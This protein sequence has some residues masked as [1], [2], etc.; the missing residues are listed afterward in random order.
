MQDNPVNIRSVDAPLELAWFADICNGDYEFLGAPDPALRSSFEH[1]RDMTLA[2]ERHGFQNILLP[3]SYQAGQDTLTFAA[4]LAGLTRNI[5]LLAA[6]RCGEVHPPMLARALATLDHLLAGRLTVN[7]ISSDLPGTVEPPSVRYKKSREVIQI[8]KQCWTAERIEFAGDYY[9]F[10]L[11][12]TPAKPYQQNGGP[13][14]YFGGISEEARE[15]CAEFCDVFL[16]WPETEDR[17]ADTMRDLAERAARFGRKIDFG[18]RVHVIVRETEDEARAYAERLVSRLDDA[19]ASE[20][21]HRALDSRSAG[22]LRQDELRN[23]ADE[24]GYI[25]PFL[26]SGIGRGRSG[27]GSAI[28]GN[29]QQ[30]VAKLQR[31]VDLGVRS[32]ILSGY[33]N[34]RELD[35]FGR[36][37]MP[38]LRERCGSFPIYQGRRPEQTPATPLTHG[39]RE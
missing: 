39:T 32:F 19:R 11:P 29:P 2:A 25:E 35:Y 4:A 34:L 15:L 5:N 22:V 8:L 21:K 16:M 9:K 12:A 6:V 28:V 26:W 30:V 23:A 10:S 38:V 18:Y 31:Y 17:I 37:V 27:C 20:I 7:I 24:D 36:L 3:S 14:L 13:L 1:C 33:P